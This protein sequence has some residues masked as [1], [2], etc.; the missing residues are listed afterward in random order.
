MFKIR[1]FFNAARDNDLE[2][3]KSAVE[4]GYDISEYIDGAGKN[5]AHFSAIHKSFDVL[6]YL[7]E[8]EGFSIFEEDG[9]GRT[10]DYF[11][12]TDPEEE[13]EK[14]LERLGM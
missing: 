2:F 4:N 1:D 12:G 5:L 7:I 9:F 13:R 8:E 10:V 3:I 11:L 14:L 6:D